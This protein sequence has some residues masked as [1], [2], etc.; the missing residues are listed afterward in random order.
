[1]VDLPRGALGKSE[2]MVPLP[3][4][5]SAKLKKWSICREPQA[6]LSTKSLFKKIL[7][8][9]PRAHLEALGKEVFQNK[10]NRFICRELGQLA[11]G[12]STVSPPTAI[13]ATFLCRELGLAL[14]KTFAEIPMNSSRQRPLCR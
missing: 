13:T 12:K 8:A 14:G 2:K 6:W 5:L 10:K 11:L 9:L 4:A 1:L 7:I 3:R